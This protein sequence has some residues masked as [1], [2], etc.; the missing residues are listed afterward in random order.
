MQ[1]QMQKKKKPKYVHWDRNTR[2]FFFFLVSPKTLNYAA[3]AQNAPNFFFLC[4]KKHELMHV[5]HIYSLFQ[6]HLGY[7]CHT[8]ISS[9][10]FHDTKKF[11]AF[12]SQW[13]SLG[14]LE[15]EEKVQGICVTVGIV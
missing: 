12:V 8:G 1:M 2:K 6:F 15:R 13:R 4:K 3:V 14:F 10:F 7:I 5:W 9:G 11:G